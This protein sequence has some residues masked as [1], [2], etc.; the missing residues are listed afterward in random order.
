MNKERVR[1][2]ALANG[3][4]VQHDL[5]EVLDFADAI[6]REAN[7]NVRMLKFGSLFILLISAVLG[8]AHLEGVDELRS[9]K[10]LNNALQA[11]NEK[12]RKP[13]DLTKQCV[14]WMYDTTFGSAKQRICGR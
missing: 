11:E 13:V 12:L 5:S 6:E 2:I 7:N 9:Q 1:R 10:L 3:F 8:Y 14:A 4:K